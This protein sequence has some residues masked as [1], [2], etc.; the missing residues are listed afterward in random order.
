[1]EN[2]TENIDDIHFSKLKYVDDF[3]IQEIPDKLFN[4]DYNYINY[5]SF[6]HIGTTNL[7]TDFNNL[8]DLEY[9]DADCSFL[10]N[11][12]LNNNNFQLFKHKE[13]KSSLLDNTFENVKMNLIE[14]I[15]YKGNFEDKL[16]IEKPKLEDNKYEND[17]FSQI[18]YNQTAINFPFNNFKTKANVNNLSK[19][20]Y[21]K[22][23]NCKFKT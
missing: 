23:K 14:E 7:P 10:Q 13:K 4:N 9:L 6:S 5:N 18:S 8:T 21:L 15:E 3:N 16:T 20:P 11:I 2:N 22:R 19:K 12:K 17:F 1:M